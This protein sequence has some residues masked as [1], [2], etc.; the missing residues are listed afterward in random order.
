M[1]QPQTNQTSS[2]SLIVPRSGVASPASTDNTVLLPEP[3]RPIT[4][5]MPGGQRRSTSTVNSP[6]RAVN[7]ATRSAMLE[8]PGQPV[9]QHAQHD[10]E[11]RRRDRHVARG[12]LAQ[13]DELV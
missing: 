13:R 3:D 12:V 9:R 6:R 1:P 4:Q 11:Q 8:P 5:V 10:A 2:P 7:V